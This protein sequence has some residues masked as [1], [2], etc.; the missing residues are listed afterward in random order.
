[1]EK[2]MKWEEFLKHP[3][4]VLDVECYLG[5]SPG[6]YLFGKTLWSIVTCLNG[7]KGWAEIASSIIQNIPKDVQDWFSKWNPF[8]EIWLSNLTSLWERYHSEDIP[9][10]VD[11]P[12][13]I[14]KLGSIPTKASAQYAE[15]QALTLPTE[16]QSSLLVV[17]VI[18][19]VARLDLICCYI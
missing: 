6:K 11:W 9:T 17:G 10:G 7:Y 8:V 16:R 2:D 1:M 13:L 12:G 3:E 14:A 15:A 4:A 5:E 19:T 18:S